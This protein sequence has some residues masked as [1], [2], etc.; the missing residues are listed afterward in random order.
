[1]SPREI[2]GGGPW[3]GLLLSLG[4]LERGPQFSGGVRKQGP[5]NGSRLGRG[6]EK[7]GVVVSE[8]LHVD[9]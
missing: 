7:G 5:G 6:E 1:M 4:R 2:R 9:M 8:S 3:E